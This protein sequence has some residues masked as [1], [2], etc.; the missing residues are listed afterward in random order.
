MKTQQLKKDL[1]GKTIVLVGILGA[2]VKE[3][4]DFFTL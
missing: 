3:D 2:E 4:P 1:A